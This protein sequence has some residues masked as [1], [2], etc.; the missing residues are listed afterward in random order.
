M[1]P[2]VFL[3]TDTQGWDLEVLNGA[4]GC[5]EHVVGLMMEIHFE[6]TYEGGPLYLQE[7]QSLARLGFVPTGIFS[8]F[9]GETG[10]IVEADCVCVR[11]STTL[12]Q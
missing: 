12:G 1:E 6:Q 5:I 3:K 8:I 2:R 10:A 9:R 4:A 11:K 7:L